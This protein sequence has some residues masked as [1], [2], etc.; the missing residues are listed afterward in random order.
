MVH[1]IYGFHAF[2]NLIYNLDIWKCYNN[3][4]DHES[5]FFSPTFTYQKFLVS[6]PTGRWDLRS[7]VCPY[8]RPY[9]R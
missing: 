4:I 9:V 5:T 1:Y 7:R 6:R 8:V 2:Q 3:E